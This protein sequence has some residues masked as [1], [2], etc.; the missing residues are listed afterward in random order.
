ML[1]A[2]SP[3]DGRYSDKTAALQDF[4]SE[5]ALIRYRVFIE[6]QYFM[7]LCRLPLPQLKDIP[8]AQLNALERLSNRFG[9]EEAQRVKAIERETNHDGSMSTAWGLI[10]NLYISGSPHRT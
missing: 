8:E 1:T 2:I 6:V 5:Y 4:F 10:G 3:I 9:L 7:A